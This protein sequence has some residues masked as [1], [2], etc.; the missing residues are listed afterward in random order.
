MKRGILVLLILIT[1][2][3]AAGCSGTQQPV[4]QPAS[5]TPAPS[6]AT[7]VPPTMTI[8]PTPISQASVS[9][10]TV[11]IKDFAFVPQTITVKTGAIVRWENQDSAPH[12]IIFTDP[13]GRDTTAES[14]VLSSHQSYSRKFDAAGEFPYYC[15]IHPS[16]KGTVVVK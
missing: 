6:A 11:T 2:I 12:R 15:K 10:N 14:G 13:N 9:D 7:T 1:A 4:E 16:M 3:I 5:T 8:V